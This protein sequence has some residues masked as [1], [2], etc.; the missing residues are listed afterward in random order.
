[1]IELSAGLSGWQVLL[2]LTLVAF[3]AGWVDAIAGGGGLLAMPALL[4]AG[5]SPAQALATNKLQGSFGTF[6]AAF[7]FWRHGHIHLRFAAG[8]VLFTALGAASGASLVQV[9]D[10]GLLRTLIPVLLIG[11][12]LYFLL[13]PTLDSERGDSTERRPARLSPW[14]FGALVGSSVGFYDGFFGPGTGSFFVFAYVSL[15]GLDLRSA[16][17]HTKLLNFTSNIVALGFFAAGGQVLWLTGLCMG[18][19][20]VLG[21]WTGSHMVMRHGARLVRPLLVLVSVLI[22]LKVLLAEL[23]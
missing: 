21:A 23:Y 6:T 13:S 18:V 2:L 4:L 17:A 8:A 12:A 15:L 19:G 9:I 20:Q 3:A 16:T 7:T 11:F 22:T 5:A 1:M 10:A 14:L